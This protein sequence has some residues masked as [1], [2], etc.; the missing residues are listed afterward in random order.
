MQPLDKMN[1]R[2]NGF[3]I[4]ELLIATVVFSIVLLVVLTAFIRTSNLFYKGVTMNATQEDTR[5]LTESID[6][7]I[8][9]T[10]N[11]P[12]NLTATATSNS[13]GVF[14]TGQHRYR[15][16]IGHQMGS[17]GSGDYAIARDTISAAAGCPAVGTSAGQLPVSSATD[18]QLLDNGMQLNYLKID[19]S[20]GSRCL[21]NVHVVFY[22]GT[23]QD[24]LFSS[25]KGIIPTNTAQ[26][27]ECTGTLS[28]SQICATADFNRTVLIKS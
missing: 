5:N 24:E 9:F 21:I 26:D 18:D 11:P 23:S 25:A 4:I 2:Q 15:Y 20:G 3:T 1:K 27:A 7:D 13:S 6:N 17:G 14:C 8:K 19:C 10:S 28:S 22:G 16:R 12:A